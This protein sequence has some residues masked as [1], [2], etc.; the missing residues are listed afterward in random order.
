MTSKE[1]LGSLVAFSYRCAFIA[2]VPLLLLGFVTPFF[3][4]VSSW[5]HAA[6]TSPVVKTILYQG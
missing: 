3:K 1:P 2:E 5:P 4:R 6:A